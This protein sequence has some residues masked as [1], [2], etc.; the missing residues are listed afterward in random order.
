MKVS[1]R[2][3]YTVIISLL[4]ISFSY[5]TSWC[6]SEEPLGIVIDDSY[7]CV[8]AGDTLGRIFER[9]NDNFDEFSTIEELAEMNNIR[10]IHLI[11]VREKIYL[12]NPPLI[13]RL[14]PFR[15]NFEPQIY[16]VKPGD[17]LWR[18]YNNVVVAEYD[19][20]V[21]WAQF[22]NWNV[23]AGNVNVNNLNLIHPDQEIIVGAKEV[24]SV[25]IEDDKLATSRSNLQDI[26]VP[27]ERGLEGV[28]NVINQIVEGLI[29]EIQRVRSENGD[30]DEDGLVTISSITQEDDFRQYLRDYIAFLRE[31]TDTI[32][33]LKIVDGEEQSAASVFLSEIARLNIDQFKQRYFFIII[34]EFEDSFV[35]YYHM[36][37]FSQFLRAFRNSFRDLSQPLD[38]AEKNRLLNIYQQEILEEE[39]QRELSRLERGVSQSFARVEEIQRKL[40]ELRK[41]PDEQLDNLFRDLLEIENLL[42]NFRNNIDTSRCDLSK[43]EEI[44][45]SINNFREDFSDNSVNIEE[46]R[47]FRDSRVVEF[48]RECLIERVSIDTLDSIN[49][50]LV[51]LN[52][53]REEVISIEDSSCNDDYLNSIVSSIT[54][55]K[56]EIE[57]QNFN[58][59][60]LNDEI[61][62]IQKDIQIC[63]NS[64]RFEFELNNL[65]R[66]ISYVRNTL[67][68]EEYKLNS[69][70]EENMIPAGSYF[71]D[72]ANKFRNLY[73]RGDKLSKEEFEEL[74]FV[75]LEISLLINCLR[76]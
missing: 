6:G 31:Y 2:I 33:V 55:I 66:D 30:N 36:P 67:R 23:E 65:I 4:V 61:S 47:E 18:I 27:D 17:T 45:N 63:S 8:K 34:E 10:N 1:I 73:E 56:E 58:L 15:D 13:S 14:N 16:I 49:S 29:A 60:N 32:I 37:E 26:T 11:R 5:S 52:M 68:P 42:G 46:F 74:L 71:A 75:N 7:Y 3:M 38:D 39:L 25:R 76:S 69:C 59:E 41:Q 53:I 24:S 57:L 9:F 51:E 43:L 12:K 62:E 44:E 72:K 54:K 50:I 48:Q 70:R 20:L 28:I 19:N 22:I 64:W 21:S 35:E 40:N